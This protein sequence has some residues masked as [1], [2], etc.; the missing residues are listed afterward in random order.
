ML[1]S[2]AYVKGINQQACVPLAHLVRT[3]K[4]RQLDV[5]AYFIRIFRFVA[6]FFVFL[7][8]FLSSSS[9]SRFSFAVSRV[10]AAVACFVIWVMRGEIFG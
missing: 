1:R 7:R 3:L 6:L 5:R 2:S 8:F 9:E 10:D 4:R